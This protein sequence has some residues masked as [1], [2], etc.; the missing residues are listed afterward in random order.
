MNYSSKEISVIK[1]DHCASDNY[2][3]Q[4]AGDGWPVNIGSSGQFNPLLA[5]LLRRF[6]HD[7]SVKKIC[8]I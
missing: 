2:K 5:A 3:N 8:L 6:L 7:C 4:F 1:D